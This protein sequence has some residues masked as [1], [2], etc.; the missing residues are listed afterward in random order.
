MNIFLA[1]RWSPYTTA[2]YYE[3]AFRMLGHD[4]SHRFSRTDSP[5]ADEWAPD[6][7]LWIEAGGG[8]RPRMVPRTI[9]TIAYYIDSHTQRVW[10]VEDAKRYDH[11]FVADG[12]YVSEYGSC[13]HWLPMACDPDLHTPTVVTAPRYDVAF[14]GN[15]YPDS[16]LYEDRRRTLDA[17]TKRYKCNFQSGVY[18]QDMANVYASARVA[19]N[20]SVMGDLNMRVFEAMC[21]GRPLVTDNVEALYGMLQN[22]ADIERYADMD[23]AFQYIDFLLANP[24]VANQ[25][26]RQGRDAVIAH[27]TYTRRAAQMLRE[28]GLCA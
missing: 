9:P 14:V 25:I 4:T 12:R 22:M 11:V 6:V 10:H 13:A 15:L 16:P 3:R 1:Y 2:R 28:A 7:F 20:K 26:G 8:M 17:L 19:F 23:E 24:E 18:F 21:S 27:H 5:V